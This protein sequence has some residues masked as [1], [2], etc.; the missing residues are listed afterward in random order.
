MESGGRQRARLATVH[1]DQAVYWSTSPSQ[2]FT[3]FR[4]SSCD[5]DSTCMVL[6]AVHARVLTRVECG[7]L[8]C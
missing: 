2:R 5:L 8:F 1:Y 3:V 6:E 7:P 4:F